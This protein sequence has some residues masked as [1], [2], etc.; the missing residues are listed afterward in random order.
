[1]PDILNICGSAGG[2]EYEWDQS[3]PAFCHSR[4]AVTEADQSF[5]CMCWL[6]YE[7]QWRSSSQ[8]NKASGPSTQH[9]GRSQELVALDVNAGHADSSA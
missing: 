6:R 7:D 9:D 8:Y 2:W 1:M 3:E 5:V 4:T